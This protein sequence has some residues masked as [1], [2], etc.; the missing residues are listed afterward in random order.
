[1]K[2]K[3]Q[4]KNPIENKRINKMR[5]ELPNERSLFVI[6][7]LVILVSVAEF[8]TVSLP[9]AFSSDRSFHE[10][11]LLI[12]I[13][14]LMGGALY[15][16][17]IYIY[18]REGAIYPIFA[19]ETFV[20][21]LYLFAVCEQKYGIMIPREV[22]SQAALRV[23][24]VVTYIIAV[25]LTVI[26]SYMLLKK[27]KF[28]NIAKVYIF[29]LAVGVVVNIVILLPIK[30]IQE[31]FVPQAMPVTLLILSQCMMIET[32]DEHCLAQRFFEV[33]KRDQELAAQNENLMILSEKR[34]EM[35]ATISHET[36]TPLAVISLYAGLIAAEMRAE[37]VSEQRAKDLDNIIEQI[38]NIS[39][40]MKQYS[41][42]SQTSGIPVPV[43]AIEVVNRTA[44]VYKHILKDAG[45]TLNV[46]FPDNLP[47]VAVHPGK[48]TQVFLNLMK[49]TANHSGAKEIT[50]KA[51]DS[52]DGFITVAVTD[53]G[54]GFPPD[55]L[56]NVF[57]RGVS[58]C[59]DSNCTDCAGI[60]LAVCKS[61]I[62]TAGGQINVHNEGGA[63]IVF[64]LPIFSEGISGNESK[65]SSC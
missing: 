36:R 56:P 26:L 21:C 11:A 34:R 60:G 46:E 48:L 12:V 3:I 27:R 14:F 38:Q 61:I 50:I 18:D 22:M 53:D 1:M 28:D 65:G 44:Q 42:F 35:M 7:A 52:E 40:I 37:G 39:E 2:E 33:F 64:T 45:I 13:S 8:I 19:A 63:I 20:C 29:T 4:Q 54:K 31:L 59:K 25:S 41:D 47:E 5:K 15:H 24:S 17:F 9:Y 43:S 49:N 32:N 6:A 55:I 58:S 16:T 23:I 57:K 30:E 10:H 62:E 51:Y